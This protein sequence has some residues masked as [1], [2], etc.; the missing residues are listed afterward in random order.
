MREADMPERRLM[1][2]GVVAIAVILFFVALATDVF[3]I[4]RLGFGVFPSTMPVPE[5]VYRAFAGP[6]VLLSVLL[7]IAAYGLLKLRRYGFMAAYVGMGMW[8]FDALLVLGVTRLTQ[9]GLLGP[10]IVFIVFTIIYLWTKKD[11]F[12]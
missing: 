6:D 4:G 5:P 7:C 3:W 11:L 10:S 1:P 12:C 2:F 9:I 8:L